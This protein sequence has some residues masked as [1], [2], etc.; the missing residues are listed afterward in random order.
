MA[1]LDPAIHERVQRVEIVRAVSSVHR[2]DARVKP[3]RD[4]GYAALS[5]RQPTGSSNLKPMLCSPSSAFLPYSSSI[6]LPR[7]GA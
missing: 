5:V 3:A 4:T 7:L 2:V 6:S 1:G